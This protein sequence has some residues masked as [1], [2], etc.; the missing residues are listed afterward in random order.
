MVALCAVAMLAAPAARAADPAQTLT[1]LEGSYD[2]AGG[3]VRATATLGAAPSPAQDA[4]L[5]VYVG[6]RDGTECVGK[7]LIATLTGDPDPS[8]SWA[9][10]GENPQAQP[11][12]PRAVSGSAVTVAVTDPALAGQAYDCVWARTLDRADNATEYSRFTGVDLTVTAPP[13]APTP[14]PAPEPPPPTPVP[15]PA[16]PKLEITVDG[17]KP[18]RRNRWLPVRVEVANV[19]AKPARKVTLRA[20]PGRGA[21]ASK[22]RIRVGTLAPGKSRTVKLRLRTRR[23]ARVALTARSGKVRATERV[24]LVLRGRVPG[25]P[26]Q[27][28]LGG[29]Y[30]TLWEADPLGPGRRTGFAFVDGRW[31]YRGI[32]KGGLPACTTTTAGVDEDGDPTDGCLPYTYDPKTRALKIDGKPA[33]LSSDGSQLDIGEDT[34]G[35]TPIPPAGTTFAVSLKSIYVAG[36]WPNQI[37]TTYWLEMRK[38][39]E[40]M[41]SRQT[42]GSWGLTGTP[43]SGNFV[44]VPPDQHGVYAVLPGGRLRLTYADGSVETRTIGI[45]RDPKTGSADPA[46]DGLWLDDDPYWKDDEE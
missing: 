8:A 44:S 10:I 6:A 23:A 20:K 22:R 35:L 21:K 17:V 33:T 37:I 13:P 31:A 14:T 15:V 46:K 41:L 11:A 36:W 30:F 16:T 40:F 24:P 29:R 39:G 2:V 3:A 43:G 26:P 5:A 7:V 32:P 25:K 34:Y 1:A 27:R 38:S 9:F 12:Q 4:L 42:L 45:Y 19:G 28:G 18:L